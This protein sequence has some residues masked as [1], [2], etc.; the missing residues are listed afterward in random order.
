MADSMT[1]SEAFFEAGLEKAV[2]QDCLRE[3]ESLP[4]EEDLDKTLSYSPRHIARMKK[5]FAGEARREF[6]H[7]SFIAVRKTATAVA[8]VLVILF[9]LLMLSPN[10]RA[11][12]VNTIV[13]WFETFTRFQS[14]HAEETAFDTSWRPAYMPEGFM[15]IVVLEDVE[16][17]VV[18]IIYRSESK[19]ISL[20]YASAYASLSV[21]NEELYF[22]EKLIDGVRYFTFEAE[23]ENKGNRLLWERNG[24]RFYLTST[25]AL[26][27]LFLVAQSISLP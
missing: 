12:V 11:V 2:S 18:N 6:T 8:V 21:D 14:P 7:R 19:R 22:E 3:L 13:E 10:V 25:I 5:L 9:G 27:E 1:S 15:E 16:G 26:D 17:E 24:I 23:S 20:V 4:T